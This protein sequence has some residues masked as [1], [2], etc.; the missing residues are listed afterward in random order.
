MGDFFTKVLLLGKEELLIDFVQ[1][2]TTFIQLQENQVM[3]YQ[4]FTC[5]YIIYNKSRALF[6]IQGVAY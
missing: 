6:F 2:K 5:T 1:M 3:S 4:H